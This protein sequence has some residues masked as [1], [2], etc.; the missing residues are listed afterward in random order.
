MTVSAEGSRD[1]HDGPEHVPYGAEGAVDAL[2]GRG[3]FLLIE[4]ELATD[5]VL[6]TFVLISLRFADLCR[7]AAPCRIHG[8][9]VLAGT[10]RTDAALIRAGNEE[11]GSDGSNDDG[12]DVFHGLVWFW[13]C[14]FGFAEKFRTG[15]RRPEW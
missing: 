4:V 1:S 12:L 2:R 9:G 3:A 7:G 10:E 14:L 5:Q 11:D 13:F 6:L 15:A 8:N